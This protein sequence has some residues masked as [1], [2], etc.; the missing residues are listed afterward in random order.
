MRGK[1][2]KA[3]MNSFNGPLVHWFPLLE[4]VEILA[5]I[6]PRNFPVILIIFTGRGG[7]GNPPFP[8]VRGWA[9]RPSLLFGP[10]W[11][12]LALSGS[13]LLSNFAYTILDWLSAPLP[14]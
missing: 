1:V 10:L 3:L 12:S 7:A 4:K 9:G 11:P 13:L 5:F 2:E 6:L 8:T 14:R